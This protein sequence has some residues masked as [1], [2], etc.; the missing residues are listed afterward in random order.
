VRALV[1]WFWKQPYRRRPVRWGTALVDRFMLPH[2]IG[3]DLDD[4]LDDLQGAGFPL[5]RSWFEPHFEFR[6]PLFGRAAVRG[7]VLEVRQALEPWHVMGEEAAAGGTARFVD[8]SVERVQVKVRGAVDGRH[9]VTCNGRRVPLAPT[10]T[11]EEQVAGV[12]FRAWQPPSA[13]H[14]TI[15]VHSPLVFDLI[16]LWSGRSLGGCTYHVVHPGGR[17]YDTHP[18][19]VLEAESRRA[20]RFTPFGHTPGRVPEPPEE[21]NPDLP[22]T[23]DL[24]R[25]S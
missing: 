12:R 16:D 25:P 18:T 14:P 20:A 17:S 19:T 5:Q 8:S 21:R 22:H 7:I 9:L 11:R 1:A 2:Y 3:Q 6:F 13:L 15:P 10:E 23:L 4:V 24:R